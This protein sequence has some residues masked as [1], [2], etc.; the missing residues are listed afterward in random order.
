MGEDIGAPSE[1]RSRL[2]PDG[3][4][5]LLLRKGAYS[6]SN[7]LYVNTSDATPLHQGYSRTLLWGS[8]SCRDSQT[9]SKEAQWGNIGRTGSVGG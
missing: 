5:M 6:A 7:K 1:L 2:F 9:Y 4:R 8:R 3:L